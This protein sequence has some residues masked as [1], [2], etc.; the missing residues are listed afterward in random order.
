MYKPNMLRPIIYKLIPRLVTGA[1]LSL[2]W[3][4]FFNAEKLFSIVERPFFVMGIVFFALAWVNY[5]KLDGMR[6]HYLNESKKK[7]TK[8][9][10]KFPVDYSDDEPS[11]ADALNENDDAIATM[12]SNIL[13]G[14][15]FLLPSVF[16]LLFLARR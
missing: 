11:P 8:H 7:K 5:L 6:I 3:D 16:S 9:K 1:V 14:I 12:I 4:R 2:L 15:C 13:A 10:L